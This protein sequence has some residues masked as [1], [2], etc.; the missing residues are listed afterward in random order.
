MGNKMTSML[1]AIA[2]ATPLNP[3]QDAKRAPSTTQLNEQG[4]V[5]SNSVSN[6]LDAAEQLSRHHDAYTEH[7]IDKQPEN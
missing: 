2:N 5:E 4:T 1:T 7:G 6:P 3:H